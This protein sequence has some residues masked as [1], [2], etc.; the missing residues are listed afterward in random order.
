MADQIAS[1]DPNRIPALLI[2]DSTG[3]E[4]RQLRSTIEN[5]NAL[6]T[7]VASVGTGFTAQ[8]SDVDISV[9]ASAGYIKSLNASNIN[10]SARYLQLHNKASA[11]ANGDTA[12]FSFIIPEGAANAPGIRE[13]GTEFFGEGGYYLST[14]IAVGI[15]TTAATFTAATTTDHSINGI[16]V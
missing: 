5:P 14:G 12:I 15:S 2:H 10:A 11:P 4:T 8:F 1:R 7:T 16:Y 9:K 6:P 3:A 13:I